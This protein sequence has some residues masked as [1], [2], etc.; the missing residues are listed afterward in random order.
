LAAL[1]GT[2]GKSPAELAD[3][4]KILSE[5]QLDEWKENGFL[6]LPRFMPWGR[7]K[8]LGDE[9]D[10]LWRDRKKDDRG[11]VIDVFIG[12]HRERRI[13]LAKATDRARAKP[14]KL[15]DVYL[16]SPLVR[17]TL[18]DPELVETFDDLLEGAPILVNSV[19]MERGS[20]QRLHTDSLFIAPTEVG[21][22]VGAMVLLEDVKPGAGPF[23]YYPGS[24]TIPPY[25][26]S[27][28]RI[29][30]TEDE[31][32]DYDAYIAAQVA[33]R[34]LEPVDFVGGAGDVFIW[35]AQLLNAGA[36]IE[37]MALTQRAIVGHYLRAKEVDPGMRA[38]I[39]GDRY[40]MERDHQPAS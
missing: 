23:R 38:D 2:A 6:H 22:M 4:R 34:G 40:Y 11:L 29:E 31:R 7:L 1:D 28:G 21:R 9:L 35:H 17:E 30:L 27:D 16:V 24:H 37:D 18:L 3:E 12:T 32:A 19:T 20:Q 36:P 33:E 8:E 39:G 14:Y 26:F 13:P 10:A 5:A 25:T 15:N